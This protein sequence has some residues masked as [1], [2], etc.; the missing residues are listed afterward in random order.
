MASPTWGS[1]AV[2]PVGQ[3]GGGAGD[4]EDVAVGAGAETEVVYGDF[5]QGAHFDPRLN[6]D[7]GRF[8][9]DG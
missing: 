4:F 7:G 5:A 1:G 9:G 3:V 6:R 2:L 8:R